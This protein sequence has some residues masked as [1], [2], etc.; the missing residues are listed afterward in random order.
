MAA[1]LRVLRE[2]AC[3]EVSPSKVLLIKFPEKLTRLRPCDA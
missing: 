1:T 2:M 3:A